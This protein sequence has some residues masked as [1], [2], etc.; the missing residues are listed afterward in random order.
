MN[1]SQQMTDCPFKTYDNEIKTILCELKQENL[2]DNI[3]KMYYD[4]LY[5]SRLVKEF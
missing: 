1:Y 2:Q 5:L 3:D 4:M